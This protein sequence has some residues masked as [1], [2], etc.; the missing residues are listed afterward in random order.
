MEAVVVGAAV[1]VVTQ[2]IQMVLGRLV[3]REEFHLTEDHR[4]DS[5]PGLQ[6]EAAEV[7]VAA[8][9][10]ILQE[11]TLMHLRTTFLSW[12]FQSS[13]MRT[14]ATRRKNFREL[15]WGICR[16]MSESSGLLVFQL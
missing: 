12:I 7:A 14:S 1:V 4:V 16:T 9:V 15:S 3:L 10:E 5:D 2:E 8:A 13:L 6:V 11:V